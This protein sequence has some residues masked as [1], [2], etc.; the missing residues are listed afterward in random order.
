MILEMEE[1]SKTGMD[2]RGDKDKRRKRGVALERSWRQRDDGGAPP[3]SAPETSEPEL[4]TNTPY[5]PK[6]LSV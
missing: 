6:P 1:G 2:K 3:T 4:K 5:N